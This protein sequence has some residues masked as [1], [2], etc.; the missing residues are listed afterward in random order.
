[1]FHLIKKY[2]ASIS[3]CPN[4]I[5]E[6]KNIVADTK[7]KQRKISTKKYR[8]DKWYSGYSIWGK[9]YSKEILTEP[10]LFFSQALNVSEDVDFLVCAIKRANKGYVATKQP[11]YFY[12]RCNEDSITHNCNPKYFEQW[13]NFLDRAKQTLSD[14]PGAYRSLYILSGCY[15]AYIKMFWD[16]GVSIHD[17]AYKNSLHIIRKQI[18]RILFSPA[19]FDVKIKLLLVS[20]FPEYYRRKRENGR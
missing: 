15:L 5:I 7:W 20:L 16:A 1:M 19:P 10:S 17:E 6:K 18:P 9:L 8:F 13:Q 14:N 12:E 11:L 3:A 4:L 2:D